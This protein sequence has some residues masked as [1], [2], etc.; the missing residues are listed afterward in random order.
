MNKHSFIEDLKDVSMFAVSAL[1]H[2]ASDMVLLATSAVRFTL[3]GA[4]LTALTLLIHKAVTPLFEKM[5]NDFH[6]EKRGAL[7]MRCASFG[8]SVL[9]SD[10]LLY[11]LGYS[12]TLPQVCF[13]F[14]IAILLKAACDSKAPNT[15]NSEDYKALILP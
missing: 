15:H 13:V 7:L 6:F 8:V 10:L 4:A 1:G 11:S 9:T 14:G 2:F 12:L 5:I 3:L